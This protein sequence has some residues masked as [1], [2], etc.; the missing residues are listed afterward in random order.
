MRLNTQSRVRPTGPTFINNQTATRHPS[1]YSHF[2]SDR[3]SCFHA[4]RSD[5]IFSCASVF[6]QVELKIPQLPFPYPS[7]R[8]NHRFILTSE[9]I[10]ALYLRSEWPVTKQLLPRT[11]ITCVASSGFRMTYK[12][13]SQTLPIV[14][15]PKKRVLPTTPNVGR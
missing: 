2:G 9:P 10:R 11:I 12:K 3:G 5:M 8:H 13:K 14:I 6:S 15:A 4:R 7:Q 1:R